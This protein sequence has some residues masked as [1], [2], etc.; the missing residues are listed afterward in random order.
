MVNV[1][2]G[3]ALSDSASCRCTG[4][5]V[6][7]RRRVRFVVHHFINY[8]RLWC[9]RV[10]ADAVGNGVAVDASHTAI[11]QQDD[12]TGNQTRNAVC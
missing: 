9:R 5:N 11:S 1:V 2:L 8:L 10:A 6:D 7:R 12:K 3:L 4:G